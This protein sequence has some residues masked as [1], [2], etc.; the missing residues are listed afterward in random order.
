[1][2]GSKRFQRST[3][4][5]LDTTKSMVKRPDPLVRSQ[6]HDSL[7]VLIAR[8]AGRDGCGTQR[9]RPTGVDPLPP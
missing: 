2:L 6:A 9:G 8:A 4:E 3:Q 7:R 1:M 5:A